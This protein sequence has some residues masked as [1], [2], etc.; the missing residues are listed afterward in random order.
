[1]TFAGFVTAMTLGIWMSDGWEVS[2]S[3][4]E[5]TVEGD[6]TAAGRGG[7]V[8]SARD[9]RRAAGLHG[10]VLALRVRRRASP[11]NQADS[12]A[13]VGQLL[14]GGMWRFAIVSAVMISTLSTLWT[15]I[16]YLSRSV[17]AMGRDRVLPRSSV[18]STGATSRS[19][20]WRSSRC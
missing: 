16:L 3:T 2:A 5:E 10:R 4:S 11:H 18:G 12:L 6:D 8:G 14:G 15:T 7:I 17:Y 13:Y 19:G 20:R 9:D 1:M